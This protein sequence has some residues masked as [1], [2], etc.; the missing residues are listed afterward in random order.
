M[1]KITW[2]QSETVSS[3][4]TVAQLQQTWDRAVRKL[5]AVDQSHQRLVDQYN[6]LSAHEGHSQFQEAVRRHV[7]EAE[8]FYTEYWPAFTAAA[9]AIHRLIQ[10]SGDLGRQWMADTGDGG[11]LFEMLE[12]RQRGRPDWTRYYWHWLRDRESHAA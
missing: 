1:A 11:E 6:W 3:G 9:A 2:G 7:E 4:V 8:E 12:A 10:R 5:E